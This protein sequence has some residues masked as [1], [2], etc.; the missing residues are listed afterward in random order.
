[1]LSLYTCLEPFYE[2]LSCSSSP[3]HKM[4]FTLTD[5]LVNAI[6]FFLEVKLQQLHC[7]I[8]EQLGDSLL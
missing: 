8:H 3:V 4:T 5:L 7:V 6:T 2:F 1:M